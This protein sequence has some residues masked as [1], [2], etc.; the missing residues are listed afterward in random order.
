MAAGLVP[1]VSDIEANRPLVD[2]GRDGYLFSPGDEKDLSEKL[3][4]ALSSGI[5]PQA[6]EK[7]R[8]EIKDMICWNSVA[9]RFMC[10]YNRLG[11]RSRLE[12]H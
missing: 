2:H 1:V 4:A 3:L 10:S 6:L 9:K 11:R 12:G 5:P 7:K 8:K